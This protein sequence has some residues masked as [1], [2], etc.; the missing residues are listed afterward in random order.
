MAVVV[1]LDMG[2]G[3]LSQGFASVTAQIW[4][5]KEELILKHRFSGSLPGNFQLLELYEQWHD[6]Y[7]NLL[8]IYRGSRGTFD[9][10]VE[11]ET[12][13][14]LRSANEDQ[15]VS[16]KVFKELSTELVERLN[17]WLDSESFLNKIELNICARL[18]TDEDEIWIILQTE[19]AQIQRLPWHCWDFFDVYQ[20]AELALSPLRFGNVPSRSLREKVRILAILGNSQGIN[21][22]EDRKTLETFTQAEIVFLVEPNIQELHQ[23]LWEHQGWDILFFAGH[24]STSE[25]NFRSGE[26]EIN[27]HEAI[28]ISNLKNTLN[29]AISKGLQLAIFNSC[30]GLGLASSL[31]DLNIPQLIVMRESVPDVV[32]QDFLKH[33]LFALSNGRPFY[34]AVREAREKLQSLENDYRCASWLPIIFQNPATEPTD[35]HKLLKKEEDIILLPP[36]EPKSRFKVLRLFLISL[37]ISALVMGIRWLGILQGSELQAYDQLMRQRP[38]EG[39]DDRLI[40]VQVT[41]DDIKNQKEPPKNRASL[42]DGVFANLFAKLQQYEPAVIGLDIYRDFPVDADHAQLANYLEQTNV[43]GICKTQD[44]AGGDAQGIAPPP[45]LHSRVGFSDAFSDE[46]GIT[47]RMILSMNPPI[48]T[49][50]CVARNH[51]SFLLALYYLQTQGV[52]VSTTPTKQLTFENPKT[53][54]SFV[55]K[56]VT[57]NFGGYQ[58]IDARGRQVMLNYRAVNSVLNVA[59]TLTVGDIINNK[60]PPKRIEQLKHKIILI[61]V[62]DTSSTKN[63]YWAT[64]YT[65]VLSLTEKETPGVFLQAHNTSQIVSAVLDNR[66]L[67]WVLPQ[68]AEFLWIFVWSFLGSVSAYFLQKRLYLSMGI[69]AGIL[70]IYALCSVFLWL[71]G[72]LPLIPAVLGL[73]LSA[74]TIAFLGYRPKKTSENKSFVKAKIH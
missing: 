21:V 34:L 23:K 8:E 25:F 15:G 1:V 74:A 52:K 28:T 72:W 64:P 27:K 11:Y 33:W 37:A 70:V 46:D 10:A 55:L 29:Q 7:N 69:A 65:R 62:V 3:D 5:R 18:N 58:K 47:R 53:N 22:Q 73:I 9:E 40:V 50:P 59:R 39:V 2:N 14:D 26:I 44:P 16:D 71:G 13:E 63:D 38:Y 56:P 67:I 20:N 30:D 60:V 54:T 51:L 43:F 61:G 6:Y 66:P 49:D 48:L 42:G 31:A 41:T 24:S 35:W 19:N 68:V 4:D 45:E 17:R 12:D 36:P 57:P 32:A